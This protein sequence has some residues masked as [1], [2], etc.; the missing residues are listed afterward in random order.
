MA[1]YRDV[2]RA[3]VRPGDVVLDL[4]AGTGLLCYQACIAGAVRLRPHTKE[5]RPLRPRHRWLSTASCYASP[6]SS[7]SWFLLS[8]ASA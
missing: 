5:S 6:A 7:G 8:A 1:A 4:G 3:C 2:I